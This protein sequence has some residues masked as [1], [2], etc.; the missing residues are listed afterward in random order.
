MHHHHG[1][2][3]G[4]AQH[5]LVDQ[6]EQ[7]GRILQVEHIGRMIQIR[8]GI[9]PGNQQCIGA[10]G[11]KHGNAGFEAVDFENGPRHLHRV[12]TSGANAKDI[13][14]PIA[15]PL[16]VLAFTENQVLAL[17]FPVP[18][19]GQLVAGDGRGRVEQ[20]QFFQSRVRPLFCLA[21]LVDQ[22]R[23]GGQHFFIQEQQFLGFWRYV[24]IS[25]TGSDVA[26]GAEY[27][28]LQIARNALVSLAQ[29]GVTPGQQNLGLHFADICRTEHQLGIAS[30]A[31]LALNAFHRRGAPRHRQLADH[32]PDLL[33]IDA[34][35]QF[36]LDPQ[37]AGQ[38]LAHGLVGTLPGAQG[39]D[40]F[41]VVAAHL[42]HILACEFAMKD[43]EHGLVVAQHVGCA[44]RVGLALRTTDGQRACVQKLKD[45][46]AG[47]SGAALVE[48]GRH[49]YRQPVR[50]VRTNDIDAPA[51]PGFA[52]AQVQQAIAG[53]TDFIVQAGQYLLSRSEFGG[54]MCSGIGQQP[55][56]GLRK[57]IEFLGQWPI[58]GKFL[59]PIHGD[60]V[61]AHQID[62]AVLRAYRQ[63]SGVRSHR[64]HRP[65]PETGQKGES[66][67][68][69]TGHH[70]RRQR[71]LH[72]GTGQT[73]GNVLVVHLDGNQG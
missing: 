47:F 60:F 10:Q 63:R 5:H 19:A 17:G 42:Q 13:S 8:I 7:V 36:G 61:L 18:V 73:R 39:G 11:L 29:A 54:L 44:V 4:F 31:H 41:V 40:Q 28:F 20:A 25:A 69:H 30:A 72:R 57:F 26:L 49:L 67:T 58:N 52:F 51:A 45:R 48:R 34:L 43:I 3:A 9:G 33:E 35:R 68:H 70:H 12:A 21:P 6:I 65:G 66:E 37:T 56:Q 46:H 32:V 16:R 15:A 2:G 23:Q 22:A 53:L 62:Q 24:K 59:A 14:A 50:R 27:P 1:A 64:W 71:G 38:L 55:L